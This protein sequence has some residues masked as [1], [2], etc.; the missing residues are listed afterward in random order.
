MLAQ[1]PNVVLIVTDDQGY[2]EI[3]AHGNPYIK[4]PE[5]DKLYNTGVRFDNFHVNAVCSPS[6]AALMTGKYA[7]SV[8]VWN[9]TGGRNILDIKAKI[10]PQYFKE[11]G[12]QTALIG[13]W[14]LGDGYPYRPEDR[15][16]DEVFRIGA[17]SLGQV[18]DYWGNGLWN[19]HYYNG[20]QWEPTNGFSTDVQFDKG[21]AFIEKHKRQPFFLTLATT[22]PHAPIGADDKYVVPY[23]KMGLTSSVAKFYGMVTNIDANI[24]KL[25]N[26]LE[27][28]GLT[29]NTIL[30]FMSDN[31]SANDKKGNSFNGGMRGKKGS[32]YEGGHRV[33]CFL[34]WP[35]GG[36]VGGKQLNQLT[37]HIDILPTLLHACKLHRNAKKDS[38]TD[39]D[40]IAL[41]SY[42]KVPSKPLH[43]Y[44]IT[45]SKVKKRKIPFES[46]AVLYDQWRLVKGNELYDLQK[47]AK[48]TENCDKEY[49]EVKASLRQH[50]K[51]WFAEVSHQFDAYM[52]CEI[53]SSKTILYSMDLYKGE[54]TFP[55]SKAVWNQKS[56]LNGT[57]FRGFWKLNCTQKGYYKF[58]LCRWPERLPYHLGNGPKNAKYLNIVK[59]EVSLDGIKTSKLLNGT[60]KEAVFVMDIPEG[61]H[62][63]QANFINHKEDIFS[64]YY[65]YIEK[66]L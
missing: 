38:K 65:V 14:H 53:N 33:P 1:K 27:A 43:R 15:G 11:A 30:V 54:M 61:V 42:I 40:G 59:A 7:S 37:A 26:K 46:S 6:R 22:A 19:G 20:S 28:C 23:L 36:W 32:L 62:T 9:T 66:V 3:A 25:R 63:L 41:N 24:A 44:L 12:Y 29:E 13:K 16:F 18:A 52:P 55:K 5:M 31:G 60:E 21:I 45:E 8:G 49:P 51:E 4:T 57:Q 56:V 34:Y 58:R 39:F 2:G 35:K 64:A 10:V 50:Y 17:G 47:D 48:Q